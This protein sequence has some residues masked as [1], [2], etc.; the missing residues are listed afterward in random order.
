MRDTLGRFGMRKPRPRKLEGRLPA[1]NVTVVSL[2]TGGLENMA[3][4]EALSTLLQGRGLMAKLDVSVPSSNPGTKDGK[5][6]TPR[7]QDEGRFEGTFPLPLR[8]LR[9]WI[10]LYDSRLACGLGNSSR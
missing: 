6:T 7:C 5:T 8:R 9:D 4:D 3:A 2:F 1:G 10:D